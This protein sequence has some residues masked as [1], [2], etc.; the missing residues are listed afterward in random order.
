M[1]GGSA[2]LDLKNEQNGSGRLVNYK[3]GERVTSLN[4]QIRF[5]QHVKLKCAGSKITNVHLCR[6]QT[7]I[8]D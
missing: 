6:G 7:L 2:A 1:K 4:S 8:I 3:L 5:H